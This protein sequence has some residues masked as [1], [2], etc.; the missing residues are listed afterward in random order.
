MEMIRIVD[1][2]FS[3]PDGT[4]ALAGVS[5]DIPA[6]MAL[7]IVGPNG[8]G[9]STL[10]NHLNGYF[11]PRAGQVFVDGIEVAKANLER[12]RR[13]VGVVFQN[14]DDQLFMPRVL[15]DVAFGLRNLGVAQ[16]EAEARARLMLERLGI[17]EL[18]D[19]A[20][21]HLSAGQK[22]FAAIAGV[23]AMEP[24]VVVM[25]EPTADLDPRNRRKTIQLINHLQITRIIVSHDLDFV[26][27][28]CSRVVLLCGGRIAAEGETQK[29]LSSR[30]LLEDH[31][32]ELP[33][34]L[35][36]AR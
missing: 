21:F 26:W 6:G 31:G 23:M 10:V 16:A 18:A 25:D 19:K 20:P 29:I 14:P 22:R 7:G 30:Q 24:S 1:L 15:D 12:I 9:K 32:L 8:A 33:L 36:G 28:T 11:L 4:A 34:R 13:K 2:S 17:A 3:Y 35:Q 5:L 27:E